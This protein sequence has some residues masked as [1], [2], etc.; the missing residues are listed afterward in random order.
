MESQLDVQMLSLVDNKEDIWYW[1][2][3]NWI[4]TFLV[5]IFNK[6]KNPDIISMSWGGIEAEQ[7]TLNICNKKLLLNMF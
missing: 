2:S 7:C 5:D 1:N 3:K 6:K 4:Y